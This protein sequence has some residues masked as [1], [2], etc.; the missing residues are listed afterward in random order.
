VGGAELDG[1]PADGAG[2]DGAGA[3]EFLEGDG[4]EV[5]AF[6]EFLE[7]GEA[8]HGVHDDGGVGAED[9]FDAVEDEG[10]AVGASALAEDGDVVG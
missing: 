4:L 5:A 8:E 2:G 10:F 1:V 6:G 3:D 9:V 7:E